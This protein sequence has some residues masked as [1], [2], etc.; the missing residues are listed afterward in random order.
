M[1][2]AAYPVGSKRASSHTRTSETAWA[3]QAVDDGPAPL[4]ID[5]AALLELS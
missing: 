1:E 4:K 5:T 3:V 2:H